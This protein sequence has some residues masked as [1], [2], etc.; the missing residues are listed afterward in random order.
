[1][2]RPLYIVFEGPKGSGKS[3]AFDRVVAELRARRVSVSTLCPT[4]PM[5]PS[6]MWERFA[7]APLVSSSDWFRERLY[8]RRSQHAARVSRSQ[9]ASVI[10]GDRSRLTSYVTRW[11]AASLTAR[12]ACKSRVDRHEPFIGDPDHVLVFDAPLELL[13]QRTEARGRR[14]GLVDE[15]PARLQAA[16]EAYEDVREH[17]AA[18]GMGAVKWHRL[19]ASKPAHAVAADA[20]ALVLR[21]I[22]Q[23]LP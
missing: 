4:R 5:P 19:D 20:L 7:R 8:A 14:Y 17:A 12:R 22:P 15:S 10:L 21:L 2:I 16:R 9:R 6:S 1:M 18:L 11:N 23:E 3:T 13:V